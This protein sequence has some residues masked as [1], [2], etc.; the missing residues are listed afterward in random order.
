MTL[1]TKRV[2]LFL[3]QTICF[4][5]FSIWNSIYYNPGCIIEPVGIDA[6]ELK[7]YDAVVWSITILV[8]GEYYYAKYTGEK[9]N[10]PFIVISNE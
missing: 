6:E 5:A 4:S 9:Y 1:P 8:D 2:K 10:P 3:K 7:Q